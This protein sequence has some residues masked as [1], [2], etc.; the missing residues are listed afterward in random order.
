MRTACRRVGLICSCLA[1]VVALA[2]SATARSPLVSNDAAARCGLV[3]SWFAQAPVDYERSRVSQWKL[4]YN[5]IYA[6]SSSGLMTAF[7]AETGETLWT[8][9]IGAPGA[10]AFGPGVNLDYLAVVSASKLYLLDRAD[11][12][13]VW[14][15]ELGS[16]P[17]AGPALSDKYAF[18]TLLSGRVEAYELADPTVQP[19]YYP[20]IGRSYERPTATGSIVSWQTTAGMLYVASADSP[21]I[22]FRLQTND[23]IIAS[24]VEKKPY[25]YAASQDGYLY[26]IHEISG[27]E[28]W[29]FSTGYSIVSKPAVVGDVTF[30]ASLEPALHAVDSQTGKEGWRAPGLT[31]FVARGKDRVYAADS[32]GRLYVLDLKTGSYINSLAVAEGT[33][34]VVNDQTDRIFLVN[35]HGLVQCLHEIG[36]DRPT[37]YREPPT[38]E[39]PTVETD[40][41]PAVNPFEVEGAG[42]EPA[43]EDQPADEEANPFGGDTNPFGADAGEV[44]SDDDNPF[45]L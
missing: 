8:T 39:A 2:G 9:S 11:G 15:R 14:S 17:A 32:S 23:E 19:W 37:K 18:V 26:C 3:R 40:E 16:A 41:E 25:L 5:R 31:Q 7:D 36:A 42:A 4:F 35:D 28:K 22:L 38:R 33:V 34:P 24:P 10:H 44:D 30:V 29:R 43:D 27:I 20:S 45:G 6:T 13:V 1:T 12:H 21:R